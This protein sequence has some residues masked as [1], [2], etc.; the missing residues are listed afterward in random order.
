MDFWYKNK[1]DIYIKTFLGCFLILSFILLS[2]KKREKRSEGELK[3]A[4]ASSTRFLVEDINK[5]LKNKTE[6]SIELITTSSGKLVSQI[7]HGAPYDIFFSA[8]IKYPA[9]LYKEGYAKTEPLIY[10]RTPAVLWTMNND[11]DIENKGLEILLSDKVGDVVIANP[12]TA[13]FGEFAVNILKSNELMEKINDK[14]LYGNNISQVDQYILTQNADIG[15]TSKA[16]VTSPQMKE[17]GT[18]VDIG[19]KVHPQAMVVIKQERNESQN[20]STDRFLR[21]LKSDECRKILKKYG[22]RPQKTLMAN[23]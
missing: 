7:K 5:N 3:I 6:C 16:I 12:E 14:L 15:I 22:F 13:P 8:D 19:E 10:G 21:F 9:F 2:C 18:W 17:K 23:E 4:A 1:G 20:K 11:L